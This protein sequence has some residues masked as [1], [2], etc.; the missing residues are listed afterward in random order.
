MNN[1]KLMDFEIAAMAAT[2][3]IAAATTQY[4]LDSTWNATSVMLIQPHDNQRDHYRTNLGS[5]DTT[6]KRT[7]KKSIKMESNRWKNKP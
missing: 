4:V 3:A 1:M 6:E 5:T 7:K 2:A